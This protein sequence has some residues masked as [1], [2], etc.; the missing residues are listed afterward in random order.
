MDKVTQQNAAGAEE[1]ASAAEQLSAQATTVKSTVEELAILI[2]GN[3]GAA[4]TQ[5]VLSAAKHN[6]IRKR[7][8]VDVASKNNHDESHVNLVGAQ[9]GGSAKPCSD[10][11]MSLDDNELKDF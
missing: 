1:S 4:N 7:I 5:V 10:D 6:H 2:R 3:R 11:F 9:V 8:G